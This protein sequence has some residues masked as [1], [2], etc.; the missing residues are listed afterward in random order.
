MG[1]LKE[2]NDDG[3]SKHF[4]VLHFLY[5]LALSRFGSLLI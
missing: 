3:K 5:L 2:R 4:G 1:N